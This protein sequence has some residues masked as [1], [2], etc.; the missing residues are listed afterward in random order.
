MYSRIYRNILF[1]F[2]EAVLRR[3]RTLLNLKELK[4]N[5]WLPEE[6]LRETQWR[7]LRLLLKHAYENVPY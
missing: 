1:P 4:R 3:R 7:K 5:Q 2:Y 6:R